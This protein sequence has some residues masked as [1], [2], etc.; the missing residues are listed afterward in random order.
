MYKYIHIK[1]VSPSISPGLPLMDLMVRTN[2]LPKS[3]ESPMLFT[4]NLCIVI[5][6][7]T[8]LQ[9]FEGECNTTPIGE[10]D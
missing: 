5:D 2:L 3:I 10:G 4:N 9:Q 7:S 8:Q 6:I 1:G